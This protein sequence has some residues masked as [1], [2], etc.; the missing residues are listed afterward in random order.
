VA[1]PWVRRW[2]LAY[3]AG[4]APLS[5]T[6]TDNS[7]SRS[8]SLTRDQLSGRRQLDLQLRFH[9]VHPD[10][11][12]YSRAAP[13]AT[14]ESLVPVHDHQVVRSGG[15]P[16][17]DERLRRRD[18]GRG[19]SLGAGQSDGRQPGSANDQAVTG[20]CV[21][22]GRVAMTRPG[23]PASSDGYPECGRSPTRPV[24][25]DPAGYAD[26]RAAAV[27]VTSLTLSTPWGG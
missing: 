2:G 24:V 13:G 1:L 27:S 18:G 10:L 6:A 20:H 3:P 8:L 5:Q 19:R 12:V 16:V 7:D 4:P 23:S 26:F 22:A 17:S 11:V 15:L 14:S 9:L 21:D 25:G